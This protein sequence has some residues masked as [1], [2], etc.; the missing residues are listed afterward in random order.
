MVLQ[1]RA[2]RESR[3]LVFH[4]YNYLLAW[5]CSLLLAGSLLSYQILCTS[6]HTCGGHSREI[7]RGPHSGGS[8][9][10]SVEQ[11]GVPPHALAGGG[12]VPAGLLT[13]ASVRRGRLSH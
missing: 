7:W 5:P 13:L 9:V 11:G 4:F 12:L 3:T 8:D 1:I 2:Q 6:A 10:G